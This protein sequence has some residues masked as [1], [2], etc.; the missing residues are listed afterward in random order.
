MIANLIEFLECGIESGTSI[1]Q[2]KTF[3]RSYNLFIIKVLSSL[4]IFQ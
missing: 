4:S 1:T 2:S 3:P